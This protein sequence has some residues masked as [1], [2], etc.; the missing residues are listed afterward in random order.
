M[1]SP[2]LRGIDAY[3]RTEIESR[4]PLELVVMLYDGALRFLAEARGA[5]ERKD[6]PARRA[7]MGRALAIVAELQSTLNMEAGGE[8]ST[9]LDQLYSFVIMRLTDASS[10]QDVAPL[11]EAV[12]VLGTLREGWVGISSTTASRPHPVRA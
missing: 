8:L 11:D 2:A 3:R 9:S 12:R 1:S 7:A 6:V 5:I 4:T 10:T